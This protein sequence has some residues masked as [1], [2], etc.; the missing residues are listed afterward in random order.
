MME[1]IHT[2]HQKLAQQVIQ[3]SES[4]KQIRN[5]NLQLENEIKN[6]KLAEEKSAQYRDKLLSLAHDV[7]MTEMAI[8]ILHNIGNVLN[9]LKISFELI[10]RQLSQQESQKLYLI[11]NMIK[12]NQ[13][14][15]IQFLTED[16]K[17]K[18]IIN[19]LTIVV[20]SLIAQNANNLKELDALEGSINKI[21]S[22]IAMQKN[23]GGSSE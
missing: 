1:I 16:Q 6:K 10:N 18:L 14:N 21:E 19:Y 4:K 13:H 22:F 20:N 11:V 3:L 7:G 5:A 17:G 9:S 8:S 15:L 12:E 23:I 2:S